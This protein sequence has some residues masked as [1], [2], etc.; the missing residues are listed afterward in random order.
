MPL[1][2]TRLALR[3]M[4][5]AAEVLLRPPAEAPHRRTGREGE[6]AAYFWLRER[7]YTVVAR[8]WRSPRRKGEADLIAWHAG[9]LCIVEVKT[10]STREVATA[11]AAVDEAK[12]DELRGMAREYARRMAEPPPIRFDVVSV[13]VDVDPP[14][15][16]LYPG[17]FA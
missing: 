17:A 14:E 9:F 7:G 5:R 16:T 3:V 11:E 13:Y 4:D 15:I 10:R 6:E 1:R 12:K 8:N 2:L